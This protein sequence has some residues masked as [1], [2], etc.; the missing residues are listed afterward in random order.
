MHGYNPWTSGRWSWHVQGEGERDQVRTF[1]LYDD[2]QG[3]RMD[4]IGL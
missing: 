4:A 2:I 3:T 1:D